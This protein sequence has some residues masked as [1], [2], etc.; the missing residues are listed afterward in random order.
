MVGWQRRLLQDPLSALAASSPQPAL[1]AVAGDWRH[2]PPRP[3]LTATAAG[4]KH[5]PACPVG[6]S[7]LS[8]WQGSLQG[9]CAQGL[10]WQP[11]LQAMVGLLLPLALPAAPKLAALIQEPHRPAALLLPVPWA[12]VQLRDHSASQVIWGSVLGVGTAL[13]WIVALGPCC[14]A[15]LKRAVFEQAPAREVVTE[16]VLDSSLLEL[17]GPGTQQPSSAHVVAR[18]GNMPP[19]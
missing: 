15:F 2:G 7:L 12:R 19:A 17:S 6:L 14:D 1:A 18:A 8:P 5:R 10:P 13:V 11:L 4:W 3:L 16:P 9:S